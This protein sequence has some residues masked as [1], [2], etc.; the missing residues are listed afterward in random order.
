MIDRDE[1]KCIPRFL[2]NINAEREQFVHQAAETTGF[3]MTTGKAYGA[4]PQSGYV[5]VWTNEPLS[6]DHGPFWQEYRRLVGAQ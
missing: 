6:R 1:K 5:S 2:S 4:C 3:D